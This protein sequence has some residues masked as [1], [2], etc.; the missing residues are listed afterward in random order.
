MY[1]TSLE[2]ALQINEDK[3]QGIY[4]SRSRRP[5]ES[6]QTLSGRNIPFVD[7]VKYLGV[8]SDKQVAFRLHIEMIEAGRAPCL[9][10]DVTVKRKI[11]SSVGN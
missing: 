9:V 2:F 8:I 11:R 5:P 4:S 7:S 1:A 3:T 6:H 10:F